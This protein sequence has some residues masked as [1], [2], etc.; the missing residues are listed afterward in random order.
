MVKNYVNDWIIRINDITDTVFELREMV[1]SKTLLE[2]MLPVE[3]EYPLDE[4][5]KKILGIII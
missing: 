3:Y 5:K 1:K 4:K 2:S